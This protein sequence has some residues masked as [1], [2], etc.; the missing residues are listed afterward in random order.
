MSEDLRRQ[1]V[2]ALC[3]MP[4]YDMTKPRAAT[5]PGTFVD[6]LR[7]SV[8]GLRSA[9]VGLY[10]CVGADPSKPQSVARHFGLNKNLTWKIARILECED[11]VEAA[12][13][14]P[15]SEGLGILLDGL[16]SSQ[17]DAAA[18]LER[19]RDAAARFEAMVARHAGDRPTLELLLDGLG[20]SASLGHSRKLAYRGNS[21]VW[22]IQARARVTANI[23]APSREDPNRLDLAL[24]AGF[25]G[26]RR[27]RDI[28]PWPL[29]RFSRYGDDSSDMHAPNKARSIESP[30]SPDA[31]RWIMT[32]W[33]DPP[34]PPLTT[35]LGDRDVTHLLGP[36]P[37]GRTGECTCFCGFHEPGAVPRY[38][39]TPDEWGE[40]ATNVTLPIETLLIDLF[41]HRD[42]VEAM[43]PEACVFGRPA[44]DA[45]PG[46]A[47]RDAQRL[48][49]SE[50]PVSLGEG[51][52]RVATPLMP[53]YERL[54]DEVFPR[55]GR[56]L[57]D[58]AAFRFAIA[59]PPM[60][61]LAVVRYR[62]VR[63]G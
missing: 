18:A 32:S 41:V 14:I 59:H 61:S 58:F 28:A 21:G 62:L 49:I 31:P 46:G 63:K 53:D 5:E 8:L 7:D 45:L 51:P 17:V 26:L 35:V 22:G 57:R 20:S 47:A 6:D 40:S 38:A 55:I 29:F 39:T 54:I 34:Q 36:G 60:P 43:R 25:L 3:S 10:R 16:G 42:L 52:P 15:G 37:V 23:V 33:C 4:C 11:A 2:S 1:S 27:L 19:V 56:D 13:L 24:V 44:G 30:S 50:V 48:P 12:P 9:L